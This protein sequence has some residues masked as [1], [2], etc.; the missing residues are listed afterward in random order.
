MSKAYTLTLV[1]DMYD[2][3]EATRANRAL[4]ARVRGY[5]AD[6]LESMVH[7]EADTSTTQTDWATW[8]QMVQVFDETVRCFEEVGR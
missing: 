4:P 3:L 7:M 6:F 5:A 2:R 8:V 1:P